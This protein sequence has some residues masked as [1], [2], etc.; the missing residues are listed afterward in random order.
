ML[1]KW[2]SRELTAFLEYLGS[3]S[4][5]Y[6]AAHDYLLTSVLGDCTL[7]SGSPGTRRAHRAHRYMQQTSIHKIKKRKTTKK[8]S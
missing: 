5:T 3:L 6:L 7:S 2:G 8:L 1:E 4:G